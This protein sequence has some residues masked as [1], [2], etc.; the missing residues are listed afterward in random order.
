MVLE[1]IEIQTCETNHFSKMNLNLGNIQIDSSDFNAQFPV[2]LCR[3]DETSAEERPVLEYAQVVE[4][5]QIGR[6][7]R[8]FPS[9]KYLSFV[10]QKL[11]AYIDGTF[12]GNLMHFA[13]NAMPPQS[14]YEKNV[15][16]L[17]TP[18]QT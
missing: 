1:N 11:E 15:Q 13:D 14:E 12:L 18:A 6:D 3:S 16:E 7:C 10:L 17:G 2:I 4:K 5:G 8:G 9:T